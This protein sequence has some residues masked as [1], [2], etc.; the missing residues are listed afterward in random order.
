MILWENLTPAVI[1]KLV[2]VEEYAFRDVSAV[3][4]ARQGM[5]DGSLEF[6]KNCHEEYF[7]LQLAD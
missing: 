2:N 3:F 5:G 7:K 1:V 4:A 6:W